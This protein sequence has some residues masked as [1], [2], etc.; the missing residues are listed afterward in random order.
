MQC[1]SELTAGLNQHTAPLKPSGDVKKW[2]VWEN[3]EPPVINYHI[4]RHDAITEL[5][6]CVSELVSIRGDS[7][8]DA[9]QGTL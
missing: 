8:A 2:A 3:M 7:A 9:I 6:K 4:V 1:M 5:L